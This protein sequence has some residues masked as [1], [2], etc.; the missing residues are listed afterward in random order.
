MHFDNKV[1]VCTDIPIRSEWH[2]TLLWPIGWMDEDA[3]WYGRSRPPRRPHCIRRVPIAPL[4]GHSTPL[5]LGPCLLWPRS[6]IPATAELLFAL[7]Y[8]TV[9]CL[10]CLSVTFVHCGQTVG[11]IKMKLGLQVGLGPGYTVLD[12][13]PAAPP[14]K[15]HT[16]P[17]IFEPI[18]V[19]AKWLHGSRCHL[20]R[21]YA[22]AQATLC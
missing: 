13:D 12:R 4:K 6:P 16:P 19:A 14:S 7:C 10:S 21:S 1:V 17:P 15:E 11:R 22:S 3:T 20:V 18:S 9:V 5:L 8:Q 2:P